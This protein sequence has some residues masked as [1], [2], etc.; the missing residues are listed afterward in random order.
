MRRIF[1]IFPDS[2]CE[3]CE[4]E[5]SVES[6][7]RRPTP[8]TFDKYL[9]FFLQDIPDS[10]C[11]KAG[12]AAYSDVNLIYIFLQ[13]NVMIL[14]FIILAFLGCSNPAES[15]KFRVHELPYNSNYFV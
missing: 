4:R 5:F 10:N 9:P 11:A 13:L 7:I 12:K 1:A 15:D 14:R 8:E 6:G 3:S 2:S